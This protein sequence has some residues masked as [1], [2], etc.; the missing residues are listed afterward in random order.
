MINGT[1][2]LLLIRLN[3]Y[4]SRFVSIGSDGSGYLRDALISP[5]TFLRHPIIYS[6]RI[7]LGSL[8]RPQ[9]KWSIQYLPRIQIQMK[10]SIAAQMVRSIAAQI[11]H[12]IAKAQ[13]L[14]E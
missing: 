11:L 2:N 6:R 13:G 14:R 9:L 12:F 4:V 3:E 7:N 10:R 8:A 1:N 5:S